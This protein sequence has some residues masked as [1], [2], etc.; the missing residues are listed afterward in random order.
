MGKV[1]KATKVFDAYHNT[2]EYLKAELG[3]IL[4]EQY[5]AEF[6]DALFQHSWT[7]MSE[8]RELVEST[9]HAAA[10]YYVDQYGTYNKETQTY[11]DRSA[12]TEPNK[13]PRCPLR[14]LSQTSCLNFRILTTAS[15]ANTTPKTP[16]SLTTSTALLQSPQHP[17][18]FLA[19][20]KH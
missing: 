4:E 10:R 3:N 6:S 5:G 17:M 20:D 9:A 18:S 15:L 7:G 11:D 12:L 14:M 13:A 19:L 1:R 16:F 8:V 2:I